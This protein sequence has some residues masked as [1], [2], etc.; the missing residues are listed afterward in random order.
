M[1]IS[2]IGVGRVGAT[3]AYALVLKG[4]GDELVLV[5]RDAQRLEGEAVDL[6]HASAFI[7]MAQIR[8]G[9]V[10][11]TAGS[12]VLV[13]AMSAPER[14]GATR[15]QQ[16]QANA[17][18][19]KQWVP[20]LVKLS[21]QAVILVI[22]NPVDAMTY[23]AGRLSGFAPGRV[24]G[25]GTLLDTGRFRALL[26]RASGIHPNDVRAYVL[27]EH[28]DSQFAALKAASCGGA[29]LQQ[30]PAEVAAMAEAAR[31]GGDVV[32]GAKGYTNYGV[33]T[34]GAM[35]LEAIARDSRA[36]MPV[37]TRVAE[38]EGLPA[39]G[40][41]CLSLPCVIGRGGVRKVLAVDLSETEK[42][43]L[44]QSAEV[45]RQSIKALGI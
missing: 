32:F 13:L 2:L 24:I 19:L 26:A 20:R 4:V 33:A 35:I 12:D 29:P 42:A 41:V 16:S 30:T 31:K 28:G 34:A 25:T 7:G 39:L 43:Q 37:S 15:N 11:Q 17:E 40:E 38:V 10:T 45:V 5:G 8:A 6:Q 14:A 27:G 18:L 9:D 36:V 1:K 22:S 21:P 23:L 44:Q 3:L